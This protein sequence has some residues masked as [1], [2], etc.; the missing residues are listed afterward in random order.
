MNSS[1]SR[2]VTVRL[3]SPPEPPDSV[4]FIESNRIESFHFTNW[5]PDLEGSNKLS[6][7]YCK[8]VRCDFCGKGDGIQRAWNSCETVCVC[9]PLSEAPS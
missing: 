7:V 4:L 1:S 3:L 9:S 6:S 5:R 8:G 2:P